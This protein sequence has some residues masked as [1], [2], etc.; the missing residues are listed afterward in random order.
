MNRPTSPMISR[1]PPHT[2]TLEDVSLENDVEI[3]GSPLGLPTSRQCLASPP[4]RRCADEDETQLVIHTRIHVTS[5]CVV[6]PP[7]VVIVLSITRL[8]GLPL[9]AT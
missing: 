4:D 3:I 5:S 7:R 6:I 2:D 1:L 8:K 9:R